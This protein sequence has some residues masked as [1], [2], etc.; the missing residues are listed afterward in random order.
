MKKDICRA[1]AV[2]KL[3]NNYYIRRTMAEKM[4][5]ELELGYTQI[6]DLLKEATPEIKT[7]VVDLQVKLF[8]LAEQYNLG[9][10]MAG[11]LD[12]VR[13]KASELEHALFECQSVFEDAIAE[14]V[15]VKE[16]KGS[17]DYQG[18]VAGKIIIER[19]KGNEILKPFAKRFA[20]LEKVTTDDLE[21]GLPDYIS[22]GLIRK[23]MKPASLPF[24]DD[25]VWKNMKGDER[26]G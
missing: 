3:I 21:D 14:E 8:S 22:G 25:G 11:Y 1:P 18:G 9:R 5:A 2:R 23:L 17:R 16:V 24:F 10:E 7:P 20:D 19:M 12:I 6:K 15:N 26:V 13:V 4:I